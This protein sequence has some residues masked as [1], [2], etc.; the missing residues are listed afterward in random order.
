M[1]YCTIRVSNN[2]DA[3]FP[4]GSNIEVTVN[5]QKYVM[6]DGE[7]VVVPES[8]LSGLQDASYPVSKFNED[9]SVSHYIEHRYFVQVIDPPR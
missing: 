9:G 5:E 8:V 7:T 1:K 6:K 3:G 4:K 2:P